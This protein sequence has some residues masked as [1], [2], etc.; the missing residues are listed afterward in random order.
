MG[1]AGFNLPGAGRSQGMQGPGAGVAES[2]AGNRPIMN[3]PLQ[4]TS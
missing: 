1:G 3:H 4:F 2:V